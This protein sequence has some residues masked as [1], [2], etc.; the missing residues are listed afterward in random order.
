[1]SSIGDLPIESLCFELAGVEKHAQ[2]KAKGFEEIL[3]I[4][5][6][7]G[8]HTF[9]DFASLPV[10]GISQRLGQTGVKLQQL[11]S[12]KTER[13]LKLIQTPPVFESSFE[14]DYPLAELEPLSFIL[15]RLLN[16]LCAKLNSYSLA[17]NELKLEMKL[18][19]GTCHERNLSLPHPMRDHKVFLKLLLLDT[20]LHPPPAAIVALSLACEPVKPRVTQ[21]GLFI[22]LAPEP[23]KLELTLAS[24]QTAG[25]K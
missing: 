25:R 16:Q 9:K 19:N 7:W 5:R 24:Y 18:V 21:N 12:G 10:A 2:P 4:L 13:H 8:I 20:E 6:L 1:M 15:A 22:P 14:L 17:T 3:E 11:A 23:E